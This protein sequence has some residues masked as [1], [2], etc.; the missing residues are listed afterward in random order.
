MSSSKSLKAAIDVY[1]LTVA[2]LQDAKIHNLG[3]V[4]AVRA[5]EVAPDRFFIWHVA[6]ANRQTSD[7]FLAALCTH[8]RPSRIWTVELSSGQKLNL[9]DKGDTWEIVRGGRRKV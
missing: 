3:P 2:Y 7:E 9:L 6:P 8:N 1:T 4:A 5:E